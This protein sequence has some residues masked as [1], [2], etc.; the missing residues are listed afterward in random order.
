MRI[1]HVLEAVEGG[2]ALHLKTLARAQREGGDDV[3][4]AVPR[5]RAWGLSDSAFL[6]DVAE[7]GVDAYVIPLH[8]FPFHPVNVSSARALTKIIRGWRPDVVHTHSTAAGAVA[9]PVARALRAT[10]VHTPNGVHFADN[11]RRPESALGYA[12]ERLLSPFTD[13]VVAVSLSEADVLRRAYPPS[14][15][16]VVHNGIPVP[17]IQAPVFPERPR[18]V[19]VNRLVY[20]KHPEL[21][22]R[23]MAMVR[24]KRP[25]VDALVVGDGPLATSVESLIG[26]LDPAI[27]LVR[28]GMK[29]TEAIGQAT[30]VLLT[31]RWEGAPYVPLEAMA[32]WRPVVATDVVGSRDIVE[33]GVSGFVFPS[34]DPRLARDRILKLLDDPT[35]AREMGVRGRKRLEATYGIEDMV[36]GLTMVYRS[37]MGDR[38][39]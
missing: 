16:A 18:I 25:H 3:A 17:N 19:T 13:R 21:A 36:A 12:L 6:D 24:S 10:V 9:R 33:D 22:V 32:L 35:L 29:G 4:V 30:V 28:T 8:K 1:L 2:T 20:Q 23:V 5:T 26:R 11:A 14:K 39:A 38:S 7:G 15:V 37:A 27:R 34:A 31:S